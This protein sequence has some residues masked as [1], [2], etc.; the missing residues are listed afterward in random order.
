MRL[1]GF[2]NA[3]RLSGRISGSV[4]F[5]G[6]GISGIAEKSSGAVM[7][8]V[9]I[10]GRPSKN[11][12]TAATPPDRG[13]LA[14]TTSPSALTVSSVGKNPAMKSASGPPRCAGTPPTAVPTAGS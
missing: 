4:I 9:G 12:R 13:P 14:G 11:V 7:F 10:V 5:S 2:G 1:S 8:I 6:F 3:V